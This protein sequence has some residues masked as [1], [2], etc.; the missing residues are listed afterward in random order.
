MV[1]QLQQHF[2]CC[3]PKQALLCKI[4]CII[5]IRNSRKLHHG[6]WKD[7]NDCIPK[8][9]IDLRVKHENYAKIIHCICTVASFRV[10]AN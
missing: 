9:S 10:G 2:Q 4:R 3:V 8:R 5:L 6:L 1:E 7:H